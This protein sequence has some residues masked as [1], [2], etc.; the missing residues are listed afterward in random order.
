MATNWEARRQ[1]SFQ[2]TVGLRFGQ[3]VGEGPEVLGLTGQGQD[4]QQDAD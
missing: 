2:A 4:S 3:A 1:S